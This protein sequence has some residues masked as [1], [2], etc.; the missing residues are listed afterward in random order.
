MINP[1]S[2]NSNL[3]A[4]QQKAAAELEKNTFNQVLQKTQQAQDDKSLLEA[5]Q[6]LESVFLNQI[7]SVMRSTVPAN[8]LL[9]R[10]QAEEIFQGMLD[11]E[12]AKSA[13][14]TGSIG[15]AEIIFRQL[16]QS[17]DTTPASETPTAPTSSEPNTKG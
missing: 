8:A 2:S 10:S 6:E 12:Y 14:K 5:C 3:M 4:T 1:V 11:Q 13:S 16:K 7:M 15:L 9:G 17:T